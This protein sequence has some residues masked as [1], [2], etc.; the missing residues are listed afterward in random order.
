MSKTTLQ[1]GKK[2]KKG[3]KDGEKSEVGADELESARSRL[4]EASRMAEEAKKEEPVEQ[5]RPKRQFIQPEK[6]T[7]MDEGVDML[8]R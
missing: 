4:E 1:T 7:Q 8:R 3:N 2:K 5:G 6:I